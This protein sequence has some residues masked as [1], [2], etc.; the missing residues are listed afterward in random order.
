MKNVSNIEELYSA[1]N[2]AAND[3]ENI[4]IAPGTY[5]LSANSPGGIARPNGGRLEL[6]QN[7]SLIGQADNSD[8]VKIDSSQ[9]PVASL[10]VPFS[11]PVNRSDQN[12]SGH[13]HN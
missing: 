13:E 4:T 6:R 2:D 11:S 8:A 5:V 3:G 1:I 10:R 12:R 7:M 9:L